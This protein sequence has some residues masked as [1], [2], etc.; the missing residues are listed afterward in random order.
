MKAVLAL[1][2]IT[3]ILIGRI[4]TYRASKAAWERSGAGSALDQLNADPKL[5]TL[6]RAGQAHYIAGVLLFALC[7][8]L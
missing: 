2:G 4:L 6:Y 5:R 1:L 3:L 7:F 8:F